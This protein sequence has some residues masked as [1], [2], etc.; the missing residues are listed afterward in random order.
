MT[1][2]TNQ[3]DKSTFGCFSN[4]Q[5]CLYG[6]CCPAC[7]VGKVYEKFGHESCFPGCCGVSAWAMRD[8]T[9]KKAG[10]EGSCCN[11]CLCAYCCTCCTVV[12]LLNQ[13]ETF[14]SQQAM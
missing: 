8:M 6:F 12:Q 13:A 2:G 14:P 5:N 4:F 11:D 10:I 7:A 3:W 1:Y 9:R